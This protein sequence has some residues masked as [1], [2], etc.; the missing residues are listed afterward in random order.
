MVVRL[1]FI[2]VVCARTTEIIMELML[3][4]IGGGD[5]FERSLFGWYFGRVHVQIGRAQGPYC[6]GLAIFSL[7]AINCRYQLQGITSL[8]KP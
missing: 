1:S 6:L 3:F 5:V 4:Q 7:A 2:H 8:L